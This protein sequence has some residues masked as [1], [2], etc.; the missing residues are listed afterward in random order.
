MTTHSSILAWIKP[1]ALGQL[2]VNVQALPFHH[3]FP[4]GLDMMTSA[5]TSPHVPPH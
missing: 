1:L 2:S 3:L 5:H 4:A